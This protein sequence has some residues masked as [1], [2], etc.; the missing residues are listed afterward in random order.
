LSYL[1]PRTDLKAFGVFWP[2]F[3]FD[4]DWVCQLLIEHV[5][6]N[7][8]VTEEEMEYALC[9]KQSPVVL[10]L[11]KEKDKRQKRNQNPFQLRFTLL[12]SPALITLL[13]LHLRRQSRP[14]TSNPVFCLSTPLLILPP[15]PHHCDFK[16]S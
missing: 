13:F 11:L 10:F 6:D 4:E 1:D 8:P 16:S 5:N 15:P 12:L 9:W 3:G 7:S 14:C 2:K